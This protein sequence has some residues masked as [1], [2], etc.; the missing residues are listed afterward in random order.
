MKTIIQQAF[1]DIKELFGEEAFLN[2]N[3]FKNSLGD[4]LGNRAVLASES[5]RI[6]TLLNI[7][8]V[9]M[10]AY[11]R[12][13]TAIT[14]KEYY[15]ISNLISEMQYDYDVKQESAE[16]VIGCISEMLGYVPSYAVIPGS[17]QNPVKEEIAVKVRKS[18]VVK[19]LK[20]IQQTAKKQVTHK[21]EI[22]LRN[23][24][25]KRGESLY[26][27]K[28]I[29]SALVNDYFAD[30][31]RL[32]RILRLAIQNNIAAKIVEA[33]GF[34]IGE[35]RIH[36]SAI[37]SYFSEDYGMSETNAA[38]AVRVL[39][40]GAG[41]AEEVL[42]GLTKTADIEAEKPKK[43]K[44]QYIGSIRSFGGYNWRVLDIQGKQALL[45]SDLILEKR[46]YHNKQE[47][48]TWED[49]SLR[50]YLNNDFYNKFTTADR[51][52][53]AEKTINNNDNPWFGVSSGNNTS[54]KI[55]LL[56]I[57][58]AVKYLG[59]GNM[60]RPKMTKEEKKFWDGCKSRKLLKQHGYPDQSMGIDWNG[61]KNRIAKDTTGKALW[62]W[63]RSSGFC[64][65]VA[66]CV[67]T[68]GYIDMIGDS[69]FK[70]GDGGVR[71]ALWL[72]MAK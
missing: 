22:D 8:I 2:P 4:V 32:L 49:C 37:V 69:V 36:I 51:N 44:S 23:E 31:Q 47:D 40:F 12:I 39:A 55:F 5:R 38:G 42:D 66:A 27:D 72:N 54:D 29:L 43:P 17:A 68:D 11:S 64:T 16:I 52:K 15:T 10:Q 48:I 62:W 30:D 60:T 50:Y 7:A 35:Q 34:S 70:P 20:P 21:G 45:L 57:E 56:S 18:D 14:K 9:D 25:L 71:P 19:I 53:I 46:A 3:R 13:K 28:R 24:F 65:G 61:N 59:D 41:I 58:E 33:I 67:Y 63:L 6:R 1:Q 26:K